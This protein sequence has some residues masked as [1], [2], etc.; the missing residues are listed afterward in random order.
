MIRFEGISKTYKN[1]VRALEEVDFEVKDGEFVFLIGPSG[2]GKTTLFKI[3]YGEERPDAG[4]VYFGETSVGSLNRNELSLLRRKM[5]II[6]Q[7]FKLLPTSSVFENVALVLEVLG[8]APTEIEEKVAK[9][10]EL[11]GLVGKERSFPWQISGGE[12]QR[13]AVARAIVANPVL[14]LADEPTAEVDPTLTWGLMEI[15]ERINELGT[16]IMIA[17]HDSEIVNS[18]KKRVAKLDSGRLVKDDKK[19]NYV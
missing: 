8:V 3:L 2:A 9:A 12:R 10:L 13:V 15:F 19:G 11:V 16:T 7:D 18:M 5:G 14:I 6:F 17:T 1:G 4:E